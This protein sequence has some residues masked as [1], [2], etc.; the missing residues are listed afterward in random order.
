MMKIEDIELKPC[1][2]CGRQATIVMH[3][4][5]NWDGKAPNYVNIGAGHRTWYVGCS[6]PFFESI[7]SKPRCEM[8]PHSWYANLEDAVREWN[9][10]D[11]T[12]EQENKKLKV[13]TQLEQENRE[14][15]TLI[16]HANNYLSNDGGGGSS[17]QRAAKLW[18]EAIV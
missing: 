17:V 18:E 10:R 13:L 11:D 9:K 2:F 1:P 4:G 6:Y 7:D 16:Q 14:L 12:I 15:K 5:E 8:I 3:P